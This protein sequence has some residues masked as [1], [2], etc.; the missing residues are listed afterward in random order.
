VRGP[1]RQD[2]DSATIDAGVDYHKSFSLARRTTLRFNTSTS[3]VK[4]PGVNG[5]FRVNGGV[6]LS[7]YF[8]RTW[9]ASANY[10]R[11][12]SFVPG[13]V[14]PIYSDSVGASLAGMFSTRVQFS[15]H[16]TAARG[17][18]AF[19]DATGFGSIT[20]T[21]QLSIALTR[22]VGTYVQYSAYS[23]EVPPSAITL[24][25]PSRMARQ[26]ISVGLSFYIPVYEKVRQ[27]Q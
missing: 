19:S 6:N 8:R 7:K 5:E 24:D 3:V 20:G 9:T 12:T 16:V 21:S 26:V 13:F 10:Y 17:S 11:T 27:G 4:Y 14:E 23:Y 1:G 15:A 25:M 22:Y 18:S 2:Y